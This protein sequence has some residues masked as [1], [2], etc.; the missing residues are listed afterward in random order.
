M[1]VSAVV[2]KRLENAVFPAGADLSH[3]LIDDS[4]AEVY[5]DDAYQV[6]F[7]L[8]DALEVHKRFGNITQIRY[9]RD[10][11]SRT[12]GK[13]VNGS[14]LLTAVPDDGTHRGDLIEAEDRERLKEEVMAQKD[15]SASADMAIFLADMEELILAS[16]RCGNPIVFL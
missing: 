12:L 15:P 3:V 14:L 8:D 2:Y 16:E 6:R 7:P 13:Q 1:S 4:T 11:I 10:E 9:L 5:F